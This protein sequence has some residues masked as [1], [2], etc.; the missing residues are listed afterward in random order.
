MGLIK[1]IL[2]YM[3]AKRHRHVIN[4]LQL[5]IF[6]YIHTFLLSQYVNAR[7]CKPGNLEIQQNGMFIKAQLFFM[8]RIVSSVTG[9]CLHCAGAVGSH[10]AGRI[11]F[12]TVV[13]TQTSLPCSLM[14]V[15]G[16]YSEPFQSRPCF[17]ALFLGSL[18]YVV[19]PSK[20]RFR[21][22]SFREFFRLEFSLDFVS[23]S[24]LHVHPILSLGFI[25]V[26]ILTED[27]KV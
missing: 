12:F 14:T 19:L 3:N 6:T 11:I 24:L 4:T 27:Q 10:S 18:I 22:L 8:L 9:L 17:W 20:C 23:P 1:C 13:K 15:I 5:N 26:K 2:L 7:Y 25:T 21:Q 16:L